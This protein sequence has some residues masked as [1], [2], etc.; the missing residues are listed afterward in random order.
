M[1]LGSNG[2]FKEAFLLGSNGYWGQMALGSF[3]PG[4]NWLGS[5]GLGSFCG[6]Q[7]SCNRIHYAC[8]DLIHLGITNL[9]TVVILPGLYVTTLR[10]RPQVH[11]HHLYS[12][13]HTS[14]SQVFNRLFYLYNVNN[15]KN[16]NIKPAQIW[17]T[18]TSTGGT[19]L[20]CK[21][22]FHDIFNP[23]NVGIR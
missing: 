15:S 21:L 1:A 18:D 16:I 12:N 9:L 20:I 8:F 2:P 6:G 19:Y 5:N 22:K 14:I 7:I 17:M 4:V 3:G 23:V 11:R 10:P 13:A